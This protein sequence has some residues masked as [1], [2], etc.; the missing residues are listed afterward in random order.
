MNHVERHIHSL[1]TA[2][3]MTLGLLR[4]I[5]GSQWLFQIVPRG[6]HA[7]WIA[8]HLAVAD[9]W[10]LRSVGVERRFLEEF[11]GVFGGSAPIT[12]DAGAYPE[13]S[14]VLRCMEEAHA[15]FIG[16]LASVT[17]ADLARESAGAISAY[18][19]DL[20]TLLSAHVW[21][22]GFHTGQL[23]LIRR[24]LGLPVCFG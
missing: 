6:Q 2:R 14:E 18:A 7:L 1:R 9:D 15:R 5:E 13:V 8:G 17:E 21:H 12:G 19:P 3:R 24:G 11:E 20:G 22:E 16:A 23:A 4:Q 10:G